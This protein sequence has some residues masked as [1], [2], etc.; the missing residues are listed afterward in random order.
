MKISRTYDCKSLITISRDDFKFVCPSCGISTSFLLICDGWIGDKET[1]KNTH[2][3]KCEKC[4]WRGFSTKLI[5]KYEF[6]NLNR[7]KLID[8]ML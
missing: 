6:L 4:G 2:L 7:T 3:V 5:E 8:K 1:L